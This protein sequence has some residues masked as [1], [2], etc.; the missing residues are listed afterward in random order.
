MTQARTPDGHKSTL[1]GSQRLVSVA[2]ADSPYIAGAG[3]YI[4]VDASGGNVSVTLPSARTQD[5][6][7]VRILAVGGNSVSLFP[8]AGETLNGAASQLGIT[9]LGP[10]SYRSV[11]DSNGDFGWR[12][13]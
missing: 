11:R 1:N 7:T 9:T 2:A 12:S 3:E 4:Q 6:V 10:G 5:I 8:V 13:I